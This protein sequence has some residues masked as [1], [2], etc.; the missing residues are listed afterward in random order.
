MSLIGKIVVFDI[1]Q[2]KQGT[3]KIV[4]VLICQGK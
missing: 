1:W 2:R 4:D 3:N